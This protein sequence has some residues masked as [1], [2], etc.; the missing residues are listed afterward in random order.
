MSYIEIIL[1]AISLCFDTLAVSIVQGSC[2]RNMTV[3]QR[4][5]IE[6]TF[7]IVQGLFIF[8]G[9]LLGS[10]FLQYISGFDHWVAFSLL[11]IVGGKMVLEYFKPEE[12]Q[13]CVD[14]L[15]MGTRM[16]TAVAT[17]IDALAVGISLAMTPGFG[18]IRIGITFAIVVLVT[19]VASAIGFSGGKLAAKILGKKSSLIGGLVLIAIGVKILLEHLLG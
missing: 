15:S 18:W 19:G 6:S 13:K 10:A 8:F 17:S 9:W 5:S 12:E 1:L 2:H 14:L 16:L 11:L 3:G 4:L 7:G